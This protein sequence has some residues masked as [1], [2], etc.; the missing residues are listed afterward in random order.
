MNIAMFDIEI[1]EIR[2]L[3]SIECPLPLERGLE[4]SE[5]ALELNVKEKIFLY[6]YSYQMPKN[7]LRNFLHLYGF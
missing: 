4:D 3:H 2:R 6:T 1:K 5:L 7:F